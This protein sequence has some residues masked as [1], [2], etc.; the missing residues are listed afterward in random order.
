LGGEGSLTT[1]Q[2]IGVGVCLAG[3]DIGWSVKSKADDFSG[4]FPGR[5]IG[6]GGFGETWD[7]VLLDADKLRS[8]HL[9]KEKQGRT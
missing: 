4:G 9:H 8:K 1:E 6:W 3:G 7:S 5:E 2:P